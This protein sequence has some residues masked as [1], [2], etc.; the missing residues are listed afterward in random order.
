MIDDVNFKDFA[1]QHSNPAKRRFISKSEHLYQFGKKIEGIYFCESGIVRAYTI[2]NETEKENTNRFFSENEI[3][4]PFV[5]LV[6]DVPAIV[7]YQVLESGYFS[8]I[9][10]ETWKILKE[11]EPNLASKILLKMST[12]TYRRSYTYQNNCRYDTQTRRNLLLEQYPYLRRVPDEY[13]AS[14]L[15]VAR[16][17]LLRNK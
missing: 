9:P 1:E 4:V 16:R 10:I 15:A 11:Q 3:I 17:T 8:F 2:D 13:I 14:F 7:H 5:S 6:D 12:D